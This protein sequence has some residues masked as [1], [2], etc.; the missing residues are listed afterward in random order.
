MDKKIYVLHEYGSNSHYN[1]LKQLC[2]NNG[3]ELVFREFRVIHLVGSGIEHRK[4]KRILKQFVN[5][6]FLFNLTF[7]KGKKIVLGMHPYDWRLPIL[8]FI[9]RNHTIY[10]HTSF[11]LWFPNETIAYANT[12]VRKQKRIKRF[13]N[14][15]VKHIFAVTQKAKE[16][17]VSFC[18]C[19]PDKVTVVYHSYTLDLQPDKMPP[20]NTYIY[21]GRM[22]KDKGVI[23]LLD[24]FS[25]HTQLKLTLIGEGELNLMVKEYSHKYDNIV[26]KGF[27]KGLEKL[28]PFYQKNCFFILNSKK[29]KNWE[30]LFGQVLIESMSCGCIPIAVS[31]SGPKSIITNCKNGV[32]FEEG[33][34]NQALDRSQQ[35]SLKDI[36][37]VRQNAIQRGRMFGSRRLSVR[38]KT[39]IER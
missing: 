24:Y 16:S 28:M 10:Y 32:L 3:I 21:V 36:L 7:T 23:E 29:T 11:T 1:A 18:N 14:Y 5:F 38:W 25:I 30:E 31:H 12:S 34:V 35:L 6:A 4:L 39:I 8:D 17:L 37:V 13:I 9:L 15:K 26:N 2:N 19:S 33:D 22:D 27:I 20:I